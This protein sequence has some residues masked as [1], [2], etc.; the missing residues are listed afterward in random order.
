M[1]KIAL[2]ASLVVIS[3][4]ASLRI[5][6][7]EHVICKTNGQSVNTGKWCGINPIEASFGFNTWTAPG[8]AGSCRT[9][10][11]EN[12]GN[13]TERFRGKCQGQTHCEI[14]PSNSPDPAGGCNKDFSATWTCGVSDEI[15]SC[16]IGASSTYTDSAENPYD[17]RPPCIADCP[18]FR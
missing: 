7:P 18:K 15:A 11:W 13:W 10:R 5:A 14:K 2:V 3:A 1:R 4:H 9:P 12:K 8:G 17:G 6:P 16:S